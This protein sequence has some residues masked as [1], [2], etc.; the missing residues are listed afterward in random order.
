MNKNTQNTTEVITKETP[1]SIEEL[2]NDFFSSGKSTTEFE[3]DLAGKE[4]SIWD[5]KKSKY[6]LEETEQ[7]P[8]LFE[9]EEDDIPFFEDTY[10]TY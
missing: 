3:N 10:E 5:S 9:E 4:R 6:L 1:R 8:N 2:V 7:I